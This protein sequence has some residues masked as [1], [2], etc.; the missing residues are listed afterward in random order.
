MAR[1]S[2]SESRD[3][4]SRLVLPVGITVTVVWA[5]SA[6]VGLLNGVYTGVEVVSPVM[7]IFCGWAFGIN[8]VRSG[9]KSERRE[10]PTPTRRRPSKR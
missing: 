6:L 8:I 9:E 3:P 2:T 5:A 1:S 4:R 7:V 10:E